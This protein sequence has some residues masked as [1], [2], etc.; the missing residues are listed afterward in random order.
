MREDGGGDPVFT[1]ASHSGNGCPQGSATRIS[2]NWRS[3]KI[4]FEDFD[5]D[6]SEPRRRSENCAV[7]LTGKGAQP[8]YQVGLTEAEFWGDLSLRNGTT[9]T[10]FGTQFR[11]ENAAITVGLLV[12][13]EC[14]LKLNQSGQDTASGQVSN[15]GGLL[16]TS[17][18][19]DAATANPVWSG[20]VGEDGNIPGILN[21]NIRGAILGGDGGSFK[22]AGARLNFT[23][24]KCLKTLE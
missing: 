16:K 19:A 24:R 2:G 6:T 9:F 20:C 23:W 14:P 7:H 15:T 4:R 13:S 1:E 12:P 11:S 22:V 21:Y 5:G 17:F 10:W 8:G 3:A 18:S